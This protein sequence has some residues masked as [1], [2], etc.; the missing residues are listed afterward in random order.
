MCTS[1]ANAPNGLQVYDRTAKKVVTWQNGTSVMLL[2]W[3]VDNSRQCG[4]KDP[5]VWSVGWASGGTWHWG[6]IGAQWT[7]IAYTNTWRSFEDQRHR[8]LEQYWVGYGQG[9]CPTYYWS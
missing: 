8:T 1:I 6:V 4:S 7:A 3:S 5:V 9:P 2:S